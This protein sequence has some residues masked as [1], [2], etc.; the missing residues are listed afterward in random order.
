MNVTIRPDSRDQGAYPDGEM[1]MSTSI[2]PVTI[3][4]VPL[5]SS[6]LSSRSDDSIRADSAP[7]Q[8]AVSWMRKLNQ[9]RR[10]DSRRSILEI[11]ITAL[12]FAL[13]W[14]AML[15]ALKL[16]QIWLYGLLL[17]P[18]A[19]LLVRLFMIQHDCGHGSFFSNRSSNDWT[20]RILG[21]LTLTPYD[22]WKRSHAIHHASQGNLD[23]RGIGDIET[24]T[25][26]E[27]RALSNWG[28]LR[29]RLYRNPLVMFGIGPIYIFMLQSR[30]PLGAFRKGWTPWVST[31]ATNLGIA[32]IAVALIYAVGFWSFMLVHLPIVF[33]GAAAG[34]WLFY[35][36]HQ[37]EDTHWAGDESWSFP[38][39]AL[40]GSSHYDLPALLRWFT[41]N[42]GM[43]HVHHLCSRIPY[44]R[45]PEVLRDH[46]ELRDI[47]RLTL[48]QSFKCVRLTLW[49]EE[50]RRLVS[51]RE[52]AAA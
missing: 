22:H 35:V 23:H 26:R 41:A 2:R 45:L 47:S 5:E 20:G 19:G 21:V 32:L 1:L 30:L 3:E 6:A 52:M 34:V 25:V 14:G 17:L 9:Y 43:H 33:L 51:F 31:M 7:E 46:P 49:D 37:F 28:K 16:D 40:H 8:D 38:E 39:A 29:Y 15:L 11:V 50:R 24:L 13:A 27:Y 44:Y 48:W 36:Q 18:A 42:I 10:S 12:P 4:H